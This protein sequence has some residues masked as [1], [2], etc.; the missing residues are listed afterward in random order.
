[1]PGTLGDMEIEQVP[2]T[3]WREWIDANEGVIIDVRE[4]D[5]W[6]LGVLE[7]AHTVSLGDLPLHV[8]SFDRETPVLMVCRSGNRS[9][10]AAAFFKMSGYQTVANLSGGMKA[11]GLQ[12]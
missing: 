10:H 8:E 7:S 9:Q 4:P 12:E 1:M 2:A 11:L 6:E 3:E 5:E